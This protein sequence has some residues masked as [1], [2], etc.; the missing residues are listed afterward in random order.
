M[1]WY[2]R[3][4]FQWIAQ[5]LANP[6][7]GY[8]SSGGSGGAEAVNVTDERALQLSAVWSCT[9]IIT[10]A[11]SCLPLGFFT[12]EA[13]GD[14]TPLDDDHYIVRLL[15]YQPNQNMTDV[16][17]REAMTTQLVLWGNAY[18]LIGRDTRGRPVS[19]IPLIP[20]Q[21]DVI[22][23]PNRTVT[24][25][26]RTNEGTEQFEAEDI[27][28][29]KGFSAEG[30]IGF[31]PIA[32]AR[33]SMGLSVAAEQYSAG[34][35]RNGG[36]PLGTLNFKEVL[37]PD[38]RKAAHQIHE[39]I[40]SGAMNNARSWVLEGEA[41]YT[42]IGI[43]PDDLQMLESRQFQLGEIAR[44]FRVPSHL[45][46]DSEKSTSWGSGLEQLDLAF[47]KYCLTPYLKR[48]EKTISH[49]LLGRT[50]G[51]RIVIEHNVEGLLRAD[52]KARAEYLSKMV[53][54][55][56]MDRNEARQKENLPSREG[57]DELTVQVN[58]TDLDQ[59]DQVNRTG[60]TS[61]A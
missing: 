44:W 17:F 7:V 21:M 10:E 53:Q 16:E 30:V 29:L 54:N 19:L 46:N 9:R 31:S 37:T 3:R 52:S 15:K 42:P 39:D 25:V 47:L 38:Q 5:G 14:K 57:A 23:N 56:L 4:F 49:S 24:Y 1:A 22:R 20:G 12:R 43:P 36:R 45:I 34:A 11:V 6:Q 41:T 13:N 18:A 27:F 48:W 55:G 8:Q 28:H 2:P 35:F 59:L 61:N 60:E 58:M 26:Y 50:E 32:M 40:T 33:H 51:R